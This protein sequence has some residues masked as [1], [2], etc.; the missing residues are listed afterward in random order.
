[1]S[2]TANNEVKFSMEDFEKG[3]MLLGLISPISQQ[4]FEEKIE[5]D[6]YEKTLSKDKARVYFQ[7]AVLA[8]EI[9]SKLKD[10]PTFGRIKFQKLVYICENV[11]SMNLLDR[12]AKQAAG[13]FDNKFMHS[14][15]KEFQKQK[16]FSVINIKDGKYNKS[17]FIPM[18]NCNGHKQY[19]TSYFSNYDEHIQYV[20]ELFR[21]KTTDDTEL[22]AT[23]LACTLELS[24]VTDNI[25][26]NALIDLFYNWSDKKKRFNQ[27]Q[28]I[29]TFDWLKEHSLLPNVV[30][31]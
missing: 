3:L 4:E 13:P 6:A 25:K 7:R 15:N 16:W 8:A 19:Y 11:S 9:V 10:E 21:Y 26:W 5:L 23:I 20:I 24:S 30:I 28:I 12:Y 17:K 1:M 2:S 14:I 22:A 18:E 27:N 29:Q 31:N